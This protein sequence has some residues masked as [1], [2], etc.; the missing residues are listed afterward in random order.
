L[1]IDNNEVKC[2]HGTTVSRLDKEKLFYL[3]S[4]GIPEEKASKLLI[5]GF[6]D[7]IIRKIKI[8]QARKDLRMAVSSKL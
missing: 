6:F 8:K 2:S 3:K 7:P 4:R 1:E 5:K